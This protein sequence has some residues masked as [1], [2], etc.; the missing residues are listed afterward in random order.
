MSFLAAQAVGA[1]APEQFR[2][3]GKNAK[4]DKYM[5][6][7]GLDTPRRVDVEAT[8]GEKKRGFLVFTKS[9]FEIVRPNYVPRADER[10]TALKAKDCHGQDSPITFC[11]F[12]LED[13]EFSRKVDI[14]TTNRWLPDK[15][16]IVRRDDLKAKIGI[17]NMCEPGSG[18]GGVGSARNVYGF[19]AWKAKA[20]A[21]SQWVYYFDGQAK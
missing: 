13:N 18:P 3:W 2:V 1:D 4:A 12:A 11:V 17:Y 10:C 7:P 21:V 20:D 5:R 14:W 15:L 8:S 9:S 6:D 16:D 19:F